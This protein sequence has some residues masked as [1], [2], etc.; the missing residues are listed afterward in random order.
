MV[1]TRMCFQCLSQ[2]Y[3]KNTSTT[4]Q[5]N[6]PKCEEYR[7]LFVTESLITLMNY[8]TNLSKLQ[9]TN[10]RNPARITAE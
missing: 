2:Q 10:H 7:S 4:T 3:Q 6:R 5:N 1:S 8:Y 9:N